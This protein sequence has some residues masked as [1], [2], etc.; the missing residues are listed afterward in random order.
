MQQ[1][2]RIFG[3]TLAR[4]QTDLLSPA[5][6]RSFRILLRAGRMPEMPDVVAEERGE[7]EIEYVGSMA[8]AQEAS[9]VM[10]VQNWVQFLGG[11]AQLNPKV[12]DVPNWDEITKGSGNMFGVPAKMQNTSVEINQVRQENAAKQQ[13][14][15]EALLAEQMGKGAAA[16]GEGK[17]AMQ[18]AA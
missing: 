8:K 7:I 12:L 10:A 6:S 18:G 5:L 2:E 3:P 14:M 13:A 4:L 15:E 1:L 9:N 11:M 16:M 17:Q